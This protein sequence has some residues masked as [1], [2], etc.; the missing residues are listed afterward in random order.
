MTGPAFWP[1]IW[2]HF[3]GYIEAFVIV[4]VALVNTTYLT[5]MIISY[6]ALRKEA[7]PFNAK[8]VAAL[9][10]SPLVPSVSVLAPAYNEAATVRDSIR[11]MLSLRHPH[12]EVI[13]INDGSVDNTLKALTE[14]FRLY[15]S[16]R[17]AL[18]AI[19]TAPVRGVY[20]S[21]DPIPLVVIDKHNGGKADA[22]NCGLNYSRHHLVAVVDADSIIEKDALLQ[23]SRPFLT[24]PDETVAVGG[25]IRI[26]NGCVIQHGQVTAVQTPKNLLVRFQIVD[27][28]RSFLGARTALSFANTLLVISGA[29]GLFR[30]DILLDVGG[31]RRDTVGEDMELVVR[32]HRYCHEHKRR[33][34]IEFLSDSV[35]WTEAPESSRVLRRQRTRWQRGCCESI[36]M[37]RCMIGNWRYGSVGLFGL[38][39]FLACEIFGPVIEV[40]GYL[41]TIVGLGLGLISPATTLL[42]FAV[43]VLFGLLLSVGSV[44]LEEC[45]I[46]KYPNVRD[47]LALLAAA[48]LENLGFRQATLLWRLQAILQVIRKKQRVWGEMERRGF[49][50]AA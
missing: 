50:R 12:H 42:F 13:V 6:F 21:R 32:L 38:P 37:H 20:E 2:L 41:V 40:C 49:R 30:R 36:L 39:Y 17:V 46:C 19:P 31:Y 29:F 11:A 28:L 25:I 7:L 33:Y 26:A 23:I 8:E 4:Y 22:L 48:L 45:T 9:A 24:S 14:E 34:C 5:L 16:S 43:S 44:L 35:C 27:Y 1:P 3:Y 18:G 15:R 47:L 10:K